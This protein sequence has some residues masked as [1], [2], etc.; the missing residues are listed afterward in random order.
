MLAAVLVSHVRLADE[1]F[2][3]NDKAGDILTAETN[4]AAAADAIRRRVSAVQPGALPQVERKIRDRVDLW[5]NEARNPAAPLGYAMRHDGKTAALL[6]HA[7]GRDWES[8]TCLYSLRDVEPPVSLIHADHGKE[9]WIME[10]AANK[11][12]RDDGQR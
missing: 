5:R 6:K 3:E 2:N 8:F 12:G 7:T 10:L 4:F 1:A 9:E 11:D